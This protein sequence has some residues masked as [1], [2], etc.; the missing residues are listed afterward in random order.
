MFIKSIP[1]KTTNFKR[2]VNKKIKNFY[3]RN[4]NKNNAEDIINTSWILNEQLESKVVPKF[5]NF[6]LKEP[7]THNISK[8]NDNS[9]IFNK[10][11]DQ[12]T[13]P[14]FL[15]TKW[16]YLIN[17]SFNSRNQNNGNWYFIIKPQRIILILYNVLDLNRSDIFQS[18][19]KVNH[20]ES[21]FSNNIHYATYFL[22][23]EASNDLGNY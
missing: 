22:N 2:K 3:S 4:E 20:N 1:L 18:H 14:K 12:Q 5:T 13:W 7:S 21:R 17:R 23:D 11:F 16:N 9:D 15:N 8:F 19:H 6:Q 10:T